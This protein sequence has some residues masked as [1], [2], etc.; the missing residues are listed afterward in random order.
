MLL[1]SLYGDEYQW[2]T[3]FRLPSLSAHA[4]EP[5]LAVS[6]W[7]PWPPSAQSYFFKLDLFTRQQR[8]RARQ[9]VYLELQIAVS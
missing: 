5:A 6:M 1:A 2:I 9:T 7:R 4:I 3:A 8:V